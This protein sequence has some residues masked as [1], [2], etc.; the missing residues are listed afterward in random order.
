MKET[1]KQAEQPQMQVEYWDIERLV[2]Y[3][4]NPRR[5]DAAVPKMAGLIREFGFKVPIVIRSTGD[6]I[7]GHLRLKAA[8]MLG[9]TKV[10]VVLADEW[11]PAQVKAFRLAVNRSAEWAEWD[12]ELLKL[13][14]DDLKLEE[15]DLELIGFDGMEF[16][17][18]PAEGLTDPDE[19]PDVQEQT[20]SRK[21]DIWLLGKHRLMCGDSTDAGS[22]ALLMAGEKADMVFTDPPY[23]MKLD[24]DYSSMVNRLDFA[25]DKNVKNGKKYEAVIG[26]NEDFKDELILSVLNNFSYCKEIF[27]WGADYYS[28]LLEGKN[29]GSWFVWDKR[30][31]ESADKMYGSCFELVWSKAKH[32]RD[33]ARVKWAGIFGTEQEFDHKRHHPTQKPI[34]LVLWFFERFAKKEAIVTDLFGGSGSTLIACEQTGRACRMMEL[35]EHYVDVIIHRWQ[36][37]TGDVATLEGD[38]RTFAEIAE[39]RG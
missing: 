30:L 15:F 29:D 13:E 18:A 12:D 28:E 19:V 23:G 31:D 2:P 35:S 5:N 16:E 9:M 4:R 25:K 20:V 14:L 7:D 3:S 37:F 1:K 34:N 8:Q 6:V 39:E 22:V 36:D 24:T 32:K 11:T 27:L 17:D 26:D 33:I 10:P 21:G 38:G